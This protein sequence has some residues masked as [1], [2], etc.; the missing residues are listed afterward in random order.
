MTF[1]DFANAHAEGLGMFIFGCV[2]I[3]AFFA[4]MSIL[5]RKDLAK[6]TDEWTCPDG[7]RDCMR[8]RAGIRG[9]GKEARRRAKELSHEGVHEEG[10]EHGSPGDTELGVQPA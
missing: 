2:F 9:V 4:Y 8:I 10:R 6:W 5:F 1:W 3:V 7:N